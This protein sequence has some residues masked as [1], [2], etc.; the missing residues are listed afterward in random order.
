[1]HE[2]TVPSGI[3]PRRSG[4]ACSAPHMHVMLGADME[5]EASAPPEV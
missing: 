1:M 2:Y 4:D 5:R 3:V